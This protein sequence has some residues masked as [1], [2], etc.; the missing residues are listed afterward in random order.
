MTLNVEMSIPLKSVF[1]RCDASKVRKQALLSLL[2]SYYF[3]KIS[4]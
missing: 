3:I 2:F 4:L 1:T